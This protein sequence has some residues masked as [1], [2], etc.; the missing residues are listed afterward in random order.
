MQYRRIHREF[1]KLSKVFFLKLGIERM[2]V[3]FICIS[4]TYITCM[5]F[6]GRKYLMLN[7]KT[8]LCH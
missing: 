2:A 4:Y 8:K 7:R 6:V 5:S 1:L 3:C